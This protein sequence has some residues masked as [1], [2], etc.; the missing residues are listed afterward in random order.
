MTS[1]LDAATPFTVVTLN[2]NNLSGNENKTNG[3]KNLFDRCK[4]HVLI[5]SETWETPDGLPDVHDPATYTRFSVPASRANR[6]T[7]VAVYVDSRI[8]ATL[9]NLDS[10]AET[11]GRICAVDLVLPDETKRRKVVRVIGVYASPDMDDYVSSSAMTPFWS[12][13]HSLTSDRHDWIV[14]GDFNAHLHPQESFTLRQSRYELHRE[15]QQVAYRAFLN[16]SNGVDTW[17]AQEDVT[18]ER[19]WSMKADDDPSTRRILD[20]FVVSRSASIIKTDTLSGDGVTAT[21]TPTSPPTVLEIRQAVRQMPFMPIP[22]TNHRPVRVTLRL[23]CLVPKTRRGW[24]SSAPRR[25]RQP[26]G[27]AAKE[28]YGKLN[29]SLKK[30]LT[31]SP[32]PCLTP[33][34]NAECDALY[35]WCSKAFVAASEHSFSRP[36]SGSRVNKGFQAPTSPALELLLKEKKQ[37]GRAMRA[38]KE[39][40]LAALFA[41][42]RKI[43]EVLNGLFS[44]SSFGRDFDKADAIE[45]ISS[46]RKQNNAARRK[47]ERRLDSVVSC[48]SEQTAWDK[49]M[50]G[51][52]LKHLF[53][54]PTVTNPPWLLRRDET[55]GSTTLEHEPEAKLRVWTSHFRDLLQHP[56]PPAVQKPWMATSQPLHPGSEDKGGEQF[57]WPRAMTVDD[58]RRTLLHGNPRP[59]P[60]PDG[61]EKWALVHA[62]NEFLMVVTN[63]A[64]YVILSSYFPDPMKSA[65]ITPVYKRGDTTDPA[66]YRGVCHSNLMYN[67]VSTWFNSNFRDY[68]WQKGLVSPTQVAGQAG[69]QPGDM[70]SLLQQVDSC[71]SVNEETVFVL[72]RDHRQGFDRVDASGFEDALRYFGFN[73][74]VVDFERARIGRCSMMVKC[75]DGVASD[76]FVTS[77]QTKQGDAVSSTRYTLWHSLLY[78]WLLRTPSLT[79]HFPEVRTRNARTGDIHLDIDSQPGQVLRCLEATDDNLLMATSWKALR[80]I[81]R[82]AETFQEAYLAETNW[83]KSEVFTL[84]RRLNEPPSVVSVPS[85]TGDKRDVR[86]AKEPTFLNTSIIN[87]ADTL[88]KV[89]AA[90]DEFPIP[91][92]RRIPLAVIRKAVTSLLLPKIRG[93]LSLHPMPLYMA[94]EVDQVLARKIHDALGVPYRNTTALF[95]PVTQLG[96]DLPSI[97]RLNAEIVIDRVMRSL[98]HPLEPFS[99]VAWTTWHNINCQAHNCANAFFLPPQEQPLLQQRTAP[100][101]RL[102]SVA[103]A[104]AQEKWERAPRLVPQSWSAARNACALGAFHIVPT[105]DQGLA[106]ARPIHVVN[107]AEYSTEQPPPAPF[108]RDN[109]FPRTGDWNDLP[110]TEWAPKVIAAIASDWRRFGGRWG[111]ELTNVV[112][113]DR[114]RVWMEKFSIDQLVGPDPSCMDPRSLRRETYTSLVSRAFDDIL[115]VDDIET[116]DGTYAT[117]GSCHQSEIVPESTTAAVVGSGVAVVKLSKQQKTSSYDGELLAVALALQHARE[118]TPALK[119]VHIISDSLNTISAVNS[120]MERGPTPPGH[121]WKSRPAAEAYRWLMSEVDLARQRGVT[122]VMTHVRAHTNSNTTAHRLNASADQLATHGHS[123]AVGKKLPPLTAW[124]PRVVAWSGESGYIPGTWK[125]VLRGNLRKHQWLWLPEKE[126]QV[127]LAENDPSSPISSYWYTRDTKGVVVRT[128]LLT[129]LREFP[130]GHHQHTRKLGSANCPFCPE[131]EQTDSHLF[132]QCPHFAT[133]RTKAIEGAVA[134]ETKLKRKKMRKGPQSEH[135]SGVASQQD[136]TLPSSGTRQQSQS[137]V[138]DPQIQSSGG[139]VDPQDSQT[140]PESATE[141]ERQTHEPDTETESPDD[142]NMAEFRRYLTDM[143]AADSGVAWWQGRTLSPT[144]YA[145][146]PSQVSTAHDCAAI[147]TADIGRVAFQELAERKKKNKETTVAKQ[148]EETSDQEEEG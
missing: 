117:D 145:V 41:G 64:N 68:L 119:T 108:I 124:M 118:Q 141:K 122:I 137:Q 11:M 5:L 133:A 92:S 89:I 19:C 139:A 43:R 148:V 56:A 97:Y 112:G 66:N 2:I 32:P 95:L 49:V 55:G 113:I 146:A 1:Q 60:G 74:N 14:G 100:A 67:L 3:L 88:A 132:A 29:E 48:A 38:A 114:F 127:F 6:A 21:L 125:K 24:T 83:D 4:P 93:I 23:G 76:V 102:D 147:L 27:E 45:K 17:E 31:E 116:A 58:V 18:W 104:K 99:K 94:D 120:R 30:T 79:K 44:S 110:F 73:E 105:T 143:F 87:P 65:Y 131:P 52:K 123:A 144:G 72:K 121:T 109:M 25:L 78:W 26:E 40:R 71:A 96:F 33:R 136:A 75:Q 51:G 16:A 107:A 10:T 53:V 103:I 63:L 129:R 35:E 126:Q 134:K 46:K 8:K 36:R 80:V 90:I 138:G 135:G 28:A 77:G 54:P 130:T 13:V 140:T 111:E 84:G 70:I 59:S 47:E 9:V 20:R 82:M 128:Q 61:W 98:N 50:A 106:Q 12:A 62:D 142:E 22:K 91:R 34:S 57:D 15:K 69:V 39:D 86:F 115:P 37:I 81:T 85:S 101:R 7:G 42:D